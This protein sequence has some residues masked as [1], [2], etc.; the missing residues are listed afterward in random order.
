MEPRCRYT[1]VDRAR[2]AMPALDGHDLC[3]QRRQR[4]RQARL[5]VTACAEPSNQHL[6]SFQTLVSKPTDKP[7][8]FRHLRK[9][10]NWRPLFSNTCATSKGVYAPT[11]NCA[12]AL[13]QEQL[14]V[15]LIHAIGLDG[16]PDR[17][18]PLTP[19]V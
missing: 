12:I 17:I 1:R 15:H 3:F 2:V 6:A 4:K 10:S 18:K 7:S 5:K 8:I 19:G 16:P 14:Q 11:L 13:W 9:S